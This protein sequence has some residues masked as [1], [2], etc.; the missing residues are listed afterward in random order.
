MRGIAEKVAVVT[1]GASGIGAAACRRFVEE[2]ARVVIGDINGDGAAA[3]AAELGEAA[4]GVQFDAGDVASVEA[5][6]AAAVDRFGKLDF[7]YNNAAL[8]SPDVIR[9]DTEPVTIDYAV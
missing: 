5:L 7:L 3:L 2:G 4:L 6:I 1:G 8:M 9:F